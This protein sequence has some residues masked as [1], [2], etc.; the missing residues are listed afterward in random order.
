MH[1][2][3]FYKLC[4]IIGLGLRQLIYIHIYVKMHFKHRL[5][6]YITYKDNLYQ[7]YIGFKGFQW[8]S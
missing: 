3:F 4:Y 7:L 2:L 1:K 8:N 5:Y 6:E